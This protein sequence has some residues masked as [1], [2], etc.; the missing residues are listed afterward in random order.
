M[1][2]KM[3]PFESLGTVY[4]FLTM[5]LTCEEKR[6]IGR[7]SRFFHTPLHSTLPLGGS[8]RRNIAIL[9]GTEKLE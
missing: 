9:F 5:A 4:A 6:D 8:P 3:A 1:S 2:L 7:K